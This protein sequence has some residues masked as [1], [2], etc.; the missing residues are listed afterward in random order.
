MKDKIKVDKIL[1][2]KYF[3]IN[4]PSNPLKTNS[5]YIKAGIFGATD[6]QTINFLDHSR[7]FKIDSTSKRQGMIELNSHWQ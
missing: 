2:Q 1:K 5:Y 7:H 4:Y 6:A 3:Q